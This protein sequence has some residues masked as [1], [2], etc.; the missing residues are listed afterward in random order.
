MWAMVLP[1][2]SRA[3]GSFNGSGRAF[4]A[5]PLFST[6]MEW[7]L[8]FFSAMRSSVSGVPVA[9]SIIV[10]ISYPE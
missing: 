4:A 7:S 8:I 2:F 3:A 10:A 6:T 1:F 5:L 9:I